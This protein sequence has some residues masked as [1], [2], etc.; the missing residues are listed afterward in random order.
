MNKLLYVTFSMAL[1]VVNGLA[2]V[3]SLDSETGKID[4]SWAAFFS[5]YFGLFILFTSIISR[6]RK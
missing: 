4:Y 3:F 1:V 6:S 2:I 5:F